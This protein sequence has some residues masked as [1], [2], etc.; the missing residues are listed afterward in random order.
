M[1]GD[2]YCA[3]YVC[4]SP[5]KNTQ[6]SYRSKSALQCRLMLIF[7]IPYTVLGAFFTV[8]ILNNLH[9]EFGKTVRVVTRDRRCHVELL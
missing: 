9:K 2:F 8:D 7:S 3:I 5:S 6:V 1:F 4:A